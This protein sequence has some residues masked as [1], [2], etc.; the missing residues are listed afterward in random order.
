MFFLSATT[1]N[2]HRRFHSF[3]QTADKTTVVTYKKSYVYSR[4]RYWVFTDDRQIYHP[5]RLFYGVKT[6]AFIFFLWFTIVG[7]GCAQFCIV[8]ISGSHPATLDG[9]C[10]WQGQGWNL[11]T[12]L[13]SS[14]LI[15]C[16]FIFLC[17]VCCVFSFF[18]FLLCLGQTCEMELDF[19]KKHQNGTTYKQG[20]IRRLDRQTLSRFVFIFSSHGA[21]DMAG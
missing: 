7:Q 4:V 9:S 10:C 8:C 2:E 15:W 17:L 5:I 18:F 11:S 1:T 3:S 12:F 19:G 6:L 14:A 20:T 16:V 21:S 13:A